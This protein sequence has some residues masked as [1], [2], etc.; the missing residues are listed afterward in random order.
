M[1]KVFGGKIDAVAGLAAGQSGMALLAGPRGPFC[2][3]GD[4][5]QF[6]TSAMNEQ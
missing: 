1:D 5:R 2:I 6:C 3:V 4:L